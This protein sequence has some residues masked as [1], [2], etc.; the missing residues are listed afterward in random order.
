MQSSLNP[1]VGALIDLA[2]GLLRWSQMVPMLVVG[3][4]L[5]LTL[6]VM[7]ATNFQGEALALASLGESF[8]RW[9]DSLPFIDIRGW[10]E[11]FAGEDGSI[12]LNTEDFKALAG[13]TYFYGSLFAFGVAALA[14][15]LWG[16]FPRWR[17]GR[18]MKLVM[19]V[20]A[21]TS[22][23]FF[24]NYFFGSEQFNG[25]FG[26]WAVLFILFPF[27]WVIVSAYSLAVS[28]LLTKVSDMIHSPG[29]VN[30]TR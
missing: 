5:A 26:S 25:S 12:K 16:P 22:V 21:L 28:H 9:L 3:G 1:I 4:V 13:K 24:C 2:L 8:V 11:S 20:A 7:T 29:P 10:M 27:I 30:P 14:N 18:K 23:G 6:L 15:W 17:Y 19:L